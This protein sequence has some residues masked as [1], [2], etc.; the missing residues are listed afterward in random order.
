MSAQASTARPAAREAPS[1]PLVVVIIVTYGHAEDAIEAIASLVQSTHR[2]LK[3]IV[4]DNASPDGALDR[5][6]AFARGET[7]GRSAGP[8]AIAWPRAIDHVELRADVASVDIAALPALTL[9]DTGANRGYAGGNNV[10]LRWLQA[11]Q[12]W[13]YGLVL[14]PDTVVEPAAIAELV[15]RAR[16]APELGAI[17]PRIF[18]Y[19]DPNLVHQWGGGSYSR[20]R[21][22]ARLFGLNRGRDERPDERSIGKDLS[23][24]TG[25]AFFFTRE[26]LGAVGLMDEAYFL[27]YEE[28]DWCMRRG[29]FG[30]GYAHD[31]VIYHRLGA[32]IGSSVKH[33]SISRLSIYWQYKSRF[34]FARKFFPW[35][36]PSVYIATYIDMARMISKGS[37]RN[38]AL[39]FRAVHGLLPDPAGKTRT[40]PGA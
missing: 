2:R 15:R 4:C 16:S 8:V 31:A 39:V 18:S 28:L 21:G 38:A 9:V 29:R 11:S 13:D 24:I 23:Y 36:L 5:I 19:E 30:I 3:I 17:G 7:S 20:L 32:S 6:K 26:F 40:Q 37:F 33:G 12:A 14:N 35:T 1:E 22:A 34:R 10:A 25:A 27:Y